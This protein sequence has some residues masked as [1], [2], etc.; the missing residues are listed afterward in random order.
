[1]TTVSTSPKTPVMVRARHLWEVGLDDAKGRSTTLLVARVHPDRRLREAI[2]LARAALDDRLFR[3]CPPD[4]AHVTLASLPDGNVRL[5]PPGRFWAEIRDVVATPYSF[6][7]EPE[8]SPFI[9]LASTIGVPRGEEVYGMTLAYALTDIASD[10]HAQ[11][12]A[13]VREIFVGQKLVLDIAAIEVQLRPFEIPFGAHIL[14]RIELA[15]TTS[16][17][18]R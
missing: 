3:V 10:E 2:G 1:M 17:D 12:L 18:A 7:L 16:A 8:Q 11:A 5:T 14:S 4:T 9:D 6:R 15:D 13:S